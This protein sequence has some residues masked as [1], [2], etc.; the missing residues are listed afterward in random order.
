MDENTHSWILAPEHLIQGLQMGPES[1]R[2]LVCRS[3][4]S[5][6]ESQQSHRTPISLGPPSL[7][8]SKKT[9]AHNN[10]TEAYIIGL[11]LIRVCVCVSLF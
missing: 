9:A 5:G 7:C 1:S 4:E 8:V 6:F 2:M 3:E 11:D 10:Y